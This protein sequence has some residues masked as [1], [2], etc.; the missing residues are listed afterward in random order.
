VVARDSLGAKIA[1][2]SRMKLNFYREN[3]RQVFNAEAKAALHD[4]W[5]IFGAILTALSV[6]GL[7]GWEF[8]ARPLKILLYHWHVIAGWL[9]RNLLFFWPS[10]IPEV[11]LTFVVTLCVMFVRGRVAGYVSLAQFTRRTQLRFVKTIFWIFITALLTVAVPTFASVEGIFATTQRAVVVIV[12]ATIAIAIA[13]GAFVICIFVSEKTGFIVRLVRRPYL[14]ALFPACV[15]LL[16][17]PP[18]LPP[19]VVEGTSFTNQRD[20][21]W[22][23]YVV[24]ILQTCLVLAVIPIAFWYIRI[25]TAVIVVLGMLFALDAAWSLLPHRLI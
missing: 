14:V 23:D 21:P 16:S 3:E 11:L 6:A 18:S 24:T 1:T 10:E 7:V 9:W 19:I 22:I 20:W 12:G 2:I 8:S 25:F 17:L 4:A 15:L 13:Y 5:A